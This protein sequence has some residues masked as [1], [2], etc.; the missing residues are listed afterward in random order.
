MG[1]KDQRFAKSARE[2][3]AYHRVP[4]SETQVTHRSAHIQGMTVGKSAAEVNGGRDKMA[5]AE[6]ENLWLEIKG[7]AQKA[8]RAKRR[9]G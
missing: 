2:A 7:A 6:I 9:R 3:L 1:E 4:V 8:A 5:S